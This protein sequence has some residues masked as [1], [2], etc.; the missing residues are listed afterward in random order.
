MN[1]FKKLNNLLG[2]IFTTFAVTILCV[3][4]A[5]QA[6][7]FKSKYTDV[8]DKASRMKPSSPEYASNDVT[9]KCWTLPENELYMGVEQRFHIKAPIES[10]VKVLDAVN[11]YVDLFPGY[12]KVELRN[13]TPNHFTVFFEQKV[14]LFFV[15]NIKFEMLYEKDTGLPTEVVYRYQLK[16][17][18]KVKASDGFLMLVKTQKN[19]TDYIE[20]DFLDAEWG[21]GGALGKDKLW[22][23]VVEGI[24]WS[25]LSIRK[26]SESTELSAKAAR[27]A[28]KEE[29][30]DEK[31]NECVKK[32]SPWTMP[33]S[34]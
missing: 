9:L 14:P 30:L 19:E 26:K 13:S 34:L 27:S 21:L 11:E 24:Y 18:G 29:L 20:Y 25:D 22:S 28:A 31:I 17:T 33:T 32:R 8:V 23:E 10:V 4:S 6:E 16:E 3:G 12:K 7:G 15:P 1:E 5:A 2:I